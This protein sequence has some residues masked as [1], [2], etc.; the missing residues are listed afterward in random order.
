MC[1]D[2]R[3]NNFRGSESDLHMVGGIYLRELPKGLI[4]FGRRLVRRRR[5]TGAGRAVPLRACAGLRKKFGGASSFFAGVALLLRSSSPPILR[6]QA[7][8]VRIF[9]FPSR[10]G[11]R[12][13]SP[14]TGRNFFMIVEKGEATA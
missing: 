1:Y 8:S 9:L 6:R 4:P 12:L 7:G 3:V 13:E 5:H 10:S 2:R 11:G 14:A